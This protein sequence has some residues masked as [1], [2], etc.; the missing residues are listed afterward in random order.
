MHQSHYI[1]VMLFSCFGITRIEIGPKGMVVTFRDNAFPKPEALIG[2]IAR[3]SGRYKIRPDSKLV[4]MLDA[5][6]ADARLK[7]VKTVVETM[8]GLL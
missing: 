6:S 8:R 7:E 3:H 1:Y 4:V 2:H 5:A